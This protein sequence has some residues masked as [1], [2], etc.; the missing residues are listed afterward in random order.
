MLVLDKLDAKLMP[1]P[2]DTLDH[3]SGGSGQGVHIPCQPSQYLV[4]I[5]LVQETLVIR[6]RVGQSRGIA[7]LAIIP[8]ACDKS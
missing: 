2:Q 8:V 3:R 1:I 5:Q 7:L 6:A 4:L